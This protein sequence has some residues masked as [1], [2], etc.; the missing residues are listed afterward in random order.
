MRPSARERIFA[1]PP[2]SRIRPSVSRVRDAF[3]VEALEPRVLLSANP[4]LSTLRPEGSIDDWLAEE[5]VRSGWS[6]KQM[7]RLIVLSSTYRQSTE[8]SEEAAV[9]DADV[10][11]LWRYPSRRLEAEAIRDCMLAASGRLNFT[12]MPRVDSDVVTAR[13]TMPFGVAA[14]ETEA[15]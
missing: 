14:E 6:I 2:R 5:L 8:Y 10:R 11:L 13:V 15:V 4:V 9:V 12:F 1:G 3:R 7:H